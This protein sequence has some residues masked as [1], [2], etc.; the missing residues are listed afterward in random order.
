VVRCKTV[1]LEVPATAEMVI[2]GLYLPEEVEHEGPFGE[3]T[4]Y[5]SGASMR[6]V[7]QVTAVT[8]RRDPYY[9]ATYE[10]KPPGNT[11]VLHSLAREPVWYEMLRRDACP[12]IKDINVTYAG[13]S[14]LHVIVSM[15]PLTHGHAR[16]VGLELLRVPNIKHAV[17]VDDDI[18]VRDMTAVEWAIA[19]R[20]QADR[21]VIILPGMGGMH[22]D[23]SQPH[24]PTGV[25]AK[26]IIDA[27]APLSGR[28]EGLITFP[29]EKIAAI[30]GR[31]AEFGLRP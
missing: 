26:M 9:L 1:D 21:D 11:H 12:T 5:Y 22:L 16:N 25:T 29:P 18:D 15:K 20:V 28:L 31:W 19:T 6:G 10:G 27:T 2:E 4:G 23:P 7:V 24:F 14:C 8:T 3:F 30:D 13:S 17:I